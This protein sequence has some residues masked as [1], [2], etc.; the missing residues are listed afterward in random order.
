VPVRG[1][2][3]KPPADNCKQ[4]EYSQKYARTNINREYLRKR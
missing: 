2:S 1:V 3:E 4:A